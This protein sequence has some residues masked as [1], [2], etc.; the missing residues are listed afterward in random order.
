MCKK[1]FLLLRF[2][3]LYQMK[4]EVGQH[5]LNRDLVRIWMDTRYLHIRLIFL[6][7][8]EFQFHYLLF[9]EQQSFSPNER[10]YNFTFFSK[11]NVFCI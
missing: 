1:L 2:S 8:P 7:C 4:C 9:L 11:A 6:L 3:F 5:M 10:H